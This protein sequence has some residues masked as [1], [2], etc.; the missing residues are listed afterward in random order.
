MYNNCEISDAYLEHKFTFIMLHP[1]GSDASYFNQ[2]IEYINRS[3][4][5]YSIFNYVRF[6]FPNAPLIDIDFPDDK[7]FN[8]SSW[9]NYYTRYDGINK[10]DKIDYQ[11]YDMQTTRIK[12]IID[13]EASKLK[14]YKTIYLAG[15]S[16]GGTLVFDI[17]NKLPRNIGGVFAIKTIYMHNYTRLKTRYINTPIFIFSAFNDDIYTINLQKQ[18][19]KKLKKFNINWKVKQDLDH[20]TITQY[21]HQFIIKNFVS[22]IF[23]DF[24]L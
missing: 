17:L 3:K 24:K 2:F 4:N 13:R 14:T 7:Q 11:D 22:S 15:V 9:Y 21:E 8:M 23:Y 5:R 12:N 1:M 16:Q 10:I 19:F 18:C 6:I 20:Y